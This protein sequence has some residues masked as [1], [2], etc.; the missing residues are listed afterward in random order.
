MNDTVIFVVTIIT[1][2]A[3]VIALFAYKLS[4]CV[5]TCKVCGTEFHI[6]WRRA[7]W[8]Q[9]FNNDYILR[10]PGCGKKGWCAVQ[11]TKEKEQK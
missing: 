11:T 1:L 8:V 9:H 7:L 6:R 5:F 3:G 4:Q 10:C 2:A